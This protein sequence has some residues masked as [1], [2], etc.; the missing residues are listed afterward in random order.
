MMRMQMMKKEH[1]QRR[2]D[3]PPCQSALAWAEILNDL[4]GEEDQPGVDGG[5]AGH[6][7]VGVLGED[8]VQDRV[9]DL[10]TDLIGVTGSDRLAG[11]EVLLSHGCSFSRNLNRLPGTEAKVRI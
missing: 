4:A 2:H 11:E 1:R 10:I 6:A 7:G 8:R 9:A 5:L 3:R